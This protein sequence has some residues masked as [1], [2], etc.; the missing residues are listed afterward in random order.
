MPA[1]TLSSFWLWQISCTESE[2]YNKGVPHL[3]TT[4]EWQLSWGTKPSP[5]VLSPEASQ[6]LP[7]SLGHFLQR[8]S[9]RET[10]TG[11]QG[12]LLQ[13]KVL[14]WQLRKERK[15][16]TKMSLEDNQQSV[17]EKGLHQPAQKC[18][19]QL[20]FKDAPVPGAGSPGVSSC[21]SIEH[22]GAPALL[23]CHSKLCKHGKNSGC[24]AT[25]VARLAPL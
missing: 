14:G 5:K 2:G 1:V 17:T 22:P 16:A 23:L 24:H 13:R 9:G 11:Q 18:R 7:A 21:M 3:Q 25:T 15:E 10:Q 20:R 6:Q 12:K 19:T 8:W 4:L